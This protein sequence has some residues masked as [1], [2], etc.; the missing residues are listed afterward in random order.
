VGDE[1]RLLIVDDTTM[2]RQ[3]SE[4]SMVVDQVIFEHQQ[5]HENLFRWMRWTD[6]EIL[7]KRDGMGIKTLELGFADQC[8]FRMISS[9]PFLSFL[10][11]F[12][13]SKIIAK[14]NSGLIRKS[15]AVGL[16]VVEGSEDQD[17]FYGGRLLERLWLQA[18][19][20]GLAFQPYGGMPFLLTRIKKSG[21]VG[22]SQKHYRMLQNVEKKLTDFAGIKDNETLI[23]LFRLG[24]AEPPSERT[25]R[26]P[27]SE[28]LTA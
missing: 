8:A 17:Y 19:A 28:V 9:W 16:L 23:M 24:N 7:D 12:G 25:N 14:I 11:V 2:I 5:L 10:N 3:L 21:N 26:R 18:T 1:A 22:F 4:I 6:Q 13:V 27:L 20:E 15:A